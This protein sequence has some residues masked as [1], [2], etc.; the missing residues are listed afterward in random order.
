VLHSKE[1][2]DQIHAKIVDCM[3]RTTI[4]ERELLRFQA[5]FVHLDHYAR[6]IV[7][8]TKHRGINEVFVL[9]ANLSFF[10][11]LHHFNFNVAI[12]KHFDVP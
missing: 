8:E 11:L 10:M 2:L 7:A 6:G 3:G 12:I 5:L 4:S 1:L 9:G